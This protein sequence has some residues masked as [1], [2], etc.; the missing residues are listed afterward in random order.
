[1]FRDKTDDVRIEV[2]PGAMYKV[3]KVDY[4]LAKESSKKYS[5]YELISEGENQDPENMITIYPVKW[6]DTLCGIA[7]KYLGDTKLF[8]KIAAYNDIINPNLIIA[9]DDKKKGTQ[10]KQDVLIIFEDWKETAKK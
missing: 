3:R 4:V 10:H 8:K 5:Y 2:A 7:K 1:M 9:G 6:E